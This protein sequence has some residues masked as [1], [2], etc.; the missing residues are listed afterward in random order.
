ML[1]TL[2]PV[3]KELSINDASYV[4]GILPYR[5]GDNRIEGVVVT[6]VDITERARAEEELRRSEVRYRELV[7]NANS[8][9]VRWKVDGTITFFNEYAQS[10]FGYRAED[11]LGKHVGLLVPEKESTGADPTSLIQDIASHPERHA[12]NVNENVCRDGR[13]V[14]MAWTNRPIFDESGQISEILAVGTDITELK[15]RREA[16]RASCLL[17]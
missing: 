17:S 3:R 11:V 14:W 2:A 8:A 6:Y 5:T 7:Q 1:D 4:R 16:H 12:N 10:F 9:I 13:R 15:L